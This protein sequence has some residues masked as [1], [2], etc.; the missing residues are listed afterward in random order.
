MPWQS[1][2]IVVCGDSRYND[3][4]NFVGLTRVRH[5]LLIALQRN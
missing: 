3:Y 1:L 5:E 2:E 4:V